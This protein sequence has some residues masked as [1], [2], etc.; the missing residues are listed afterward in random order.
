MESCYFVLMRYF[1]RLQDVE[2]RIVET[3]FYHAFGSNYLLR[4]TTEKQAPFSAL[5]QV[6]F[7]IVVDHYSIRR[8]WRIPL[9]YWTP[10]GSLR[11]SRRRYRRTR[12]G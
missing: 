2:F 8:H 4:E 1:M 5:Q 11:I 6:A 3:R 7:I 9:F 12:T 10:T